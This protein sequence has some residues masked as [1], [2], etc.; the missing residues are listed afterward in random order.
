MALLSNLKNT[1][2]KKYAPA[3]K[4]CIKEIKKY[5]KHFKPASKADKKWFWIITHRLYRIYKFIQ[6]LY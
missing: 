3:E 4:Q 2:D 1:K 6:R 5:K